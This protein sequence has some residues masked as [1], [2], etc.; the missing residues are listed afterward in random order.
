MFTNL[1]KEHMTKLPVW[2]HFN[3]CIQ[4]G[5][6]LT[7]NISCF[8]IYGNQKRS[9]KLKFQSQ[10]HCITSTITIKNLMFNYVELWSNLLQTKRD[11]AYTF[12]CRGNLVPK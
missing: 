10:I 5:N 12:A 8:Y 2:L 11:G 9:C 7:Q 1:I 6:K 4:T 3:P